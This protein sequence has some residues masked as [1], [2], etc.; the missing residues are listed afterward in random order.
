MTA[1]T[2]AFRRTVDQISSARLHLVPLIQHAVRECAFPDP[3]TVTFEGYTAQRAPD[4]WFHPSSH[5]TLDERKLY[6]YLTES[7]SWADDLFDYGPRMSVL[8]GSATHDIFQHTMINIGLLLKPKGI[9][10][11]CLRPH[12]V[13][14]GECNEW[15]VSDAALRRRGHI[16]GLLTLPGWGVGEGVFDLKTCSPPVI[17]GIQDH[18][19]GAFKKKWP[20]YYGQAQEYLALTGKLQAMV[21]FLAMSEGWEMREFTIPRDDVYIAALER[22][23]RSVLNHVEAGVAPPVACCSGGAAARRCPATT[24]PVKI[25]MP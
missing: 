2:P 17:R 16:D 4:G 14:P 15:G 10:R 3:F 7:D 18:D 22:K 12:G 25:G 24:C 21:L 11:C 1:F 8:M 9:C 6:Y 19:L 13:G 23:Y 20:K 5:P